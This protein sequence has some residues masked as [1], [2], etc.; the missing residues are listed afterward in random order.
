MI[1]NTARDQN[2]NQNLNETNNNNN[3]YKKK[4]KK[5]DMINANRWVLQ[6][7]KSPQNV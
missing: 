6:F 5:F 2:Q 4:T 7:D 1:S 3:N